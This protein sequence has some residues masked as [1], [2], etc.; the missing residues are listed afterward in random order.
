[1]EMFLEKKEVYINNINCKLYFSKYSG[2]HRSI[3][4]GPGTDVADFY[5]W[6]NNTYE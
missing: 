2:D 1:M 3:H 5:V 6:L 4:A